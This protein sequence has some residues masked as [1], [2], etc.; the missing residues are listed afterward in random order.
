[1]H[2]WEK[3]LKFLDEKV[4]DFGAQYKTFGL[5]GVINYPASYFIML[6]YIGTSEN[7][8]V[9]LIAFLLCVP[10]IFTNYWPHKLKKYLNL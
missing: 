9:R 6:Y 8:L 1:M 2:L 3:F 5:F 7:A 10:L 4:E